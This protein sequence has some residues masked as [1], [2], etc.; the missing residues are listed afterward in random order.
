MVYAKGT[1]LWWRLCVSSFR[2]IAYIVDKQA[3]YAENT[4]C[5]KDCVCQVSKLQR[6]YVTDLKWFFFFKFKWKVLKK[7]NPNLGGLSRGTF[8]PPCSNET[9]SLKI[10][11]SFEF[12]YI[13]CILYVR[14]LWPIS[15]L[16]KNLSWSKE[17][18]IEVFHTANIYLFKFNDVAMVF[19]LLTL[20][21]LHTFFV[22]LLSALNK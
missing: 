3:V 1:F 6:I 18:H 8:L 21:I 10:I 14:P 15:V 2:T 11:P 17:V 9:T 12:A 13:F 4:F 5:Y 16:T 22:F 7:I 19:S 20:N